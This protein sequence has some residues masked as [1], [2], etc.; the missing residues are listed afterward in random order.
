MIQKIKTKKYHQ[1][2]LFLAI[3]VIGYLCVIYIFPNLRQVKNCYDLFYRKY[4]TIPFYNECGERLN[5]FYNIDKTDVVLEIGGNIGSTSLI[6]ADKL[7]NSQNL[8]VIEPSE[9]ASTIL[10]QNKDKH[11]HHFSI[12]KGCLSKVP[13][14]EKKTYWWWFDYLEVTDNPKLQK[15]G[16]NPIH[17]IT[18]QQLQERYKLQFTTLVIDCEGCYQQIFKDFPEILQQVDKILIEW[19]GEF[20][21]PLLISHK[22]TKVDSYYHP[23]LV[24]GV[25]TY[26]KINNRKIKK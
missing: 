26:K 9:K 15:I 7:L 25:A 11:N 19:D 13:L 24:K 5:A 17:T 4:P 16:S 2:I 6:I 21:E 3:F 8:V 22:F 23:F 20:L 18:Y 1:I 10:Q 12:F 14:Y